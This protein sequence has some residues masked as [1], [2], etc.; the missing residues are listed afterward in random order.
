M[1]QRSCLGT[2][3]PGL[4]LFSTGNVIYRV[5]DFT[6]I[7]DNFDHYVTL[8]SACWSSGMILASGAR[9]PGFDSRTGPILH[10][11]VN[12]DDS[13]LQ[14]FLRSHNGHYETVEYPT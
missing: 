4:K 11:F 8:A 13:I 14:W 2:D 9:G 1:P 7:T 3:N 12:E 5:S 6:A 10:S